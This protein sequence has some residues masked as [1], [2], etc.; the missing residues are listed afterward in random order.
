MAN[1]KLSESKKSLGSPLARPPKK[2]AE[3]DGQIV[4]GGLMMVHERGDT[5]NVWAHYAS[6]LT[7]P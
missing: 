1:L 4:L 7:F 3:I 2:V 6:G 5:E